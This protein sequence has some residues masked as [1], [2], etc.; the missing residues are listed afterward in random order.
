MVEKEYNNRGFNTEKW[1]K[2]VNTQQSPYSI[3]TY[4]F[5]KKIAWSL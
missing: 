5:T 3:I 2:K 1:V 4:F